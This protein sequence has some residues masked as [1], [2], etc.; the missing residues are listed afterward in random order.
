MLRN[1]AITLR[2]IEMKVNQCQTQEI[3]GLI[4]EYTAGDLV[5]VLSDV[6][7]LLF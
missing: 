1:T 2:R 5:V 7:I 6:M 3:V 4:I